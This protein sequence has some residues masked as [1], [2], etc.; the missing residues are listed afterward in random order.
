LDSKACTQH[1]LTAWRAHGGEGGHDIEQ[2]E[3]AR[4]ANTTNGNTEKQSTWPRERPMQAT[5]GEEL[6]G[7]QEGDG[8]RE[9]GGPRGHR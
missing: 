1:S 8:A 7:K 6:H 3:S 5:R 2:H 4:G 9:R